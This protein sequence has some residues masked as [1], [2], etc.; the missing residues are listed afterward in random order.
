MSYFSGAAPDVSEPVK[1]WQKLN[2]SEAIIKNVK[3]VRVPKVVRTGPGSG[4]RED[5]QHQP[6]SP[7]QDGSGG[8]ES[9]V[10]YPRQSDA[11]HRSLGIMSIEIE[12][13]CQTK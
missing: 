9:K 12:F 11:L 6:Q 8:Q 7:S 13:E 10:S 4:S 3:T 5:D 1:K 2:L